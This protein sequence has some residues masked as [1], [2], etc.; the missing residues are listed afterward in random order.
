MV[1]A[2]QAQ[3]AYRALEKQVRLAGVISELCAR[4]LY[5]HVGLVADLLLPLWLATT[6]ASWTSLK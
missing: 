5:A 4:T 3:D 2:V 6:F 1:A